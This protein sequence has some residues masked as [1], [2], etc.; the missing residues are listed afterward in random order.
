MS[1]LSR[2]TYLCTQLGIDF[3]N[4]ELYAGHKEILFTLPNSVIEDLHNSE[5][6]DE[7]YD[8]F[9]EAYGVWYAAESGCWVA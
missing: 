9:C 8:A 1:N 2:I 6:P 5:D 4:V 3:E 7:K